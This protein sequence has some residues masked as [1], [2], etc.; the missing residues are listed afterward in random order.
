MNTEGLV[1]LAAWTSWF[2]LLLILFV[3]VI[4][5]RSHGD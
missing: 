1:L 4:R 5:R 3:V 2:A